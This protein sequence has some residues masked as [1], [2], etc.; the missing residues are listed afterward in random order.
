MNRGDPTS[1]YFGGSPGNIQF[2]AP[3]GGRGKDSGGSD[4]IGPND[5]LLKPVTRGTN[6]DVTERTSIDH[7]VMHLPKDAKPPGARFD[8]VTPLANQPAGPN[9]DEPRP[10]GTH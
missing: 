7:D 3:P 6:P 9:R 10:S 1:R 5:P 4:Q 2:S 8:V